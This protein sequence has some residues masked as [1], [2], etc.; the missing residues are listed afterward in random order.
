MK[1]FLKHM[2]LKNPTELKKVILPVSE[3]DF[4]YLNSNR[5]L[6]EDVK[7]QFLAA[8]DSTPVVRIKPGTTIPLP[9]GKSTTITK[10]MITPTRVFLSSPMLKPFPIQVEKT[11]SGW[12]IDARVVIAARK[13]AAKAREKK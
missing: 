13:A 7:K 9:G 3:E 6:P 10:E 2:I 12:R 5:K 8:V 1:S 4:K 11:D